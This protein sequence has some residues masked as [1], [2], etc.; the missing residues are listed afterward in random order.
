VREVAMSAK[1]TQ[2]HSKGCAADEMAKKAAKELTTFVNQTLKSLT[3][4]IILQLITNK[5]P[6][7][8]ELIKECQTDHEEV[9]KA[10]QR[11]LLRMLCE[12]NRKA[13]EDA[14]VVWRSQ[15]RGT[16]RLFRIPNWKFKNCS[17]FQE[18]FAS[19]IEAAAQLADGRKTGITY[20]TANKVRLRRFKVRKKALDVE[21]AHTAEKKI[22]LDDDS[23][24]KKD[25]TTLEARILFNEEGA[26]CETQGDFYR[27]RNS[28]LAAVAYFEDFT[29]DSVRKSDETYVDPVMLP[30]SLFLKLIDDLGYGV[31]EFW[32]SGVRYGCD[33]V[34]RRNRTDPSRPRRRLELTPEQ[35]KRLGET[36]EPVTFTAEHKHEQDLIEEIDFQVDLS[37]QASAFTFTHNTTVK[38]WES[39]IFKVL[40]I[41]GVL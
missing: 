25:D 11:R 24:K 8:A 31:M 32:L 2:S 41:A 34:S 27:A 21:V 3:A 36:D 1:N 13:V 38:G 26:V 37:N 17:E 29:F 28:L 40:E 9:E 18:K 35:R 30:K 5:L 10:D 19:R 12:V 15:K 33:L 22:N 23:E 14:L 7:G 4:P 16:V 20:S 39:T 6:N